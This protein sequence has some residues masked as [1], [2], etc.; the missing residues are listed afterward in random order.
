M[1]FMESKHFLESRM[2]TTSRIT[3]SPSPVLHQYHENS[4]SLSSPSLPFPSQLTCLPLRILTDKRKLGSLARSRSLLTKWASPS[5]S[6]RLHASHWRS[7]WGDEY[8]SSVVFNGDERSEGGGGS[9]SNAIA[10]EPRQTDWFGGARI[11]GNTI[12]STEACLVN[13]CILY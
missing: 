3:L 5:P 8:G 2:K 9:C 4:S 12:S 7:V 13:W 10:T 11:T 6:S 1:N